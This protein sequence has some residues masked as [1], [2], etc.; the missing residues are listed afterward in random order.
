ME[1]SMGSQRDTERKRSSV[2]IFQQRPPSLRRGFQATLFAAATALLI[3]AQSDSQVKPPVSKTDLQIVQR[4]SQILNSPAK[5]NRADN[6]K[7][8][9]DAKTVSLYCA[10]EQATQEVTGSFEHRGA[11][12]QEARFAIDEVAGNRDYQHR[13]M[14]YN[15]DPATTFDDIKK[16]IHRT[17]QRIEDRLN[18]E[19]P[20][21]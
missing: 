4:A 13:L 15:N 5:W 14:N 21:K 1:P 8:P 6:R 3:H 10:L 2:P 16:I 19:K 20:G 11:V 12:M 9:Q 18:K 7:C 17:S